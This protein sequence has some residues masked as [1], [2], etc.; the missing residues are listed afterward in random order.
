MMSG[1]I[2]GIGLPRTATKSLTA[3]LRMLGYRTAHFL[4]VP[5]WLE[6]D[7]CEDALKDYE[8]IADTPA[9]VFFPEL[10]ERYPGSK[11]ILTYR[12]TGSWLASIKT[13]QSRPLEDPVYARTVREYR[14]LTY[15]MA[16]FSDERYRYVKETHEQNVGW[17][18]RDRPGDLLRFNICGGDGWEPLC[19]FLG[20]QI[21]EDPFPKVKA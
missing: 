2:I 18:F 17:Y 12:D 1:K 14:L 15:G 9:P 11:F 8:A 16:A 3:A 10:D 21:P 4:E 7:F 19:E 13:H 6:G 5:A 20:K